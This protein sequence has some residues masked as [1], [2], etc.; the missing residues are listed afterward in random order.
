MAHMQYLAHVPIWF[1]Y[2]LQ[3]GPY[4]TKSMDTA[5]PQSG[6]VDLIDI[7]PNAQRLGLERKTNH[8]AKGNYVA[9]RRGLASAIEP[10]DAGR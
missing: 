3:N 2:H 10:S 9:P 1:T 5:A 7:H 4:Q 6:Q 8:K